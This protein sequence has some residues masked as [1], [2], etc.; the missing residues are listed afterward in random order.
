ML[1]VLF[2]RPICV[3]YVSTKAKSPALLRCPLIVSHLRAEV[4][5]RVGLLS[6]E[7]TDTRVVAFCAV[8]SRCAWGRWYRCCCC[9]SSVWLLLVF[10]PTLCVDIIRGSDGTFKKRPRIVNEGGVEV[11]L[12]TAALVK[13]NDTHIVPIL[14]VTYSRLGWPS[15]RIPSHLERER[16]WCHT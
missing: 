11:F 15:R 7:S 10:Y 12:N 16:V 13:W 9:L 5:P 3:L 4:T 2:I 1:S 14:C 8:S 6:P